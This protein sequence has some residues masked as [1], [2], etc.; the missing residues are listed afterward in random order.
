MSDTMTRPA[1]PGSTVSAP[2]SVRPFRPA[3]YVRLHER[4]ALTTGIRLVADPYAVA[5]S[6]AA[7]GP[8]FTAECSTNHILA[9]AGLVRRWPGVAL[10]W[11]VLSPALR[12]DIRLAAWFTFAVRRRL[13][14]L[15]VEH[16]FWR[17]EAEVVATDGAGI[18]WAHALGYQVEGLKPQAG[19]RREDFIMYGLLRG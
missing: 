17:I 13:R 10:G 11:A 3:D 15:M 6:Y 12:T 1:P 18:R 19:P 9:S 4:I 2:P 8:A 5:E 16:G 14:A 7:A